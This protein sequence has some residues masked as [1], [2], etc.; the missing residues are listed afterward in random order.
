MFLDEET[1][2]ILDLLQGCILENKVKGYRLKLV[3]VTM[4]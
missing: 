1:A 3:D 2:Y 4:L